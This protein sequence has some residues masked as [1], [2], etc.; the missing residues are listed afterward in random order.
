MGMSMV[1]RQVKDFL[2]ENSVQEVEALGKAF[3]PNIHDAVAQEPSADQ[4]EGT[5]LR[6]GRKGYRLKDRLLRPAS[7]VVS[8]G[9]AAV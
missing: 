6:V 3:D 5:I 7:V 4:P 8:S 1:L 9:P 2:A